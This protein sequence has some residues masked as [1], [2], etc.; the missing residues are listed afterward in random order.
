MPS[1][2][3]GGENCHLYTTFN[4]V[5]ISVLDDIAG[6]MLGNMRSRIK[7]S[8]RGRNGFPR[9]QHTQPIETIDKENP[10]A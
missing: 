2:Q 5:G 7:L 3:M 6:T 8:L 4:L 1:C 9:M 10:R